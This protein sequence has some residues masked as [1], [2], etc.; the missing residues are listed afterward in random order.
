[1]PRRKTDKFPWF[2]F[3]AKDWLADPALRACSPAARGAWI[4][5]L[6][7]MWESESPG[8]LVVNGHPLGQKNVAKMIG[9][10]AETVRELLRNNVL[11]MS[12]RSRTLFS[13]RML[14]DW[15]QNRRLAR[16]RA[17]SGS[18]GG[19]QKAS[20]RGS[21]REAKGKQTP[22]YACA[23]APAPSEIR[24]QMLE[25]D[26]TRCASTDGSN[27][28]AAQQRPLPSSSPAPSRPS[29]PRAA[30]STGSTSR[31]ERAVHPELGGEDSNGNGP[32]CA[33]DGRWLISRLMITFRGPMLNLTP[34][35]EGWTRRLCDRIAHDGRA[36]DA[37]EDAK[38][39]AADSTLRNPY[40]AWLAAWKGK[41]K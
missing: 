3:Y 25:T 32:G 8:R 15:H 31:A 35:Q 14:R 22:A 1:M 21:K 20:K 13:R 38:A 9:V 12:Q 28:V 37:A 30:P 23:Q 6:C 17:D 36:A 19:K 11:S 10:R 24:Y 26:G 4:D 5:I 29:R 41:Q 7:L 27:T 16:A 39:K 34:K 40:S 2:K 18:K 33:R